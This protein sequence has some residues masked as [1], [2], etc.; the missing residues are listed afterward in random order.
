MPEALLKR[1]VESFQL[2][3]FQ[4]Q[5]LEKNSALLNIR[6]PNYFIRVPT[7]TTRAPVNVAGCPM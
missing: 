5:R 3:V 4:A 2:F 7:K 1:K 6:A